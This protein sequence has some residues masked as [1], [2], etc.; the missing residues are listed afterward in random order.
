M[1]ILG[2]LGTFYGLADTMDNQF[3]AAAHSMTTTSNAL[4]SSIE[5]F[6]QSLQRFNENTR[7]FAE[8]MQES[9]TILEYNL[10]S[11]R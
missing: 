7:D 11:A 9:S 1:I 10:P 6:D 8:Y 4:S 5:K 3:V 2:L